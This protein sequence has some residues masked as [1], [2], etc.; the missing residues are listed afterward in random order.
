MTDLNTHIQIKKQKD[1][2]AISKMFRLILSIIL[3]GPVLTTDTLLPAFA[4]SSQEPSAGK[5]ER[6]LD[7]SIKFEDIKDI[8][9][10]SKDKT[11]IGLFKTTSDICKEILFSRNK[12]QN[13]SHPENIRRIL[14]LAIIYRELMEFKRARLLF[15]YLLDHTSNNMNGDH[16]KTA[17]LSDELGILY[18]ELGDY[19]KA[20]DLHLKALKILREK[21]INNSKRESKV[22]RN[23]GVVLANQGNFIKALSYSDQALAIEKDA[24]NNDNNRVNLA[25]IL[26]DLGNNYLNLGQL[27]KA[28]SYLE[29]A[30][31]IRED[32]LGINHIDTAHSYDD[33]PG[34]YIR[35]GSIKKAEELYLKSLK[36]RNKQLGESHPK[37]AITINR[38]ANLYMLMGKYDA[39]ESLL[40][41]SLKIRKDRLPLYHPHK[42]Y[43]LSGL[44][45]LYTKKDLT[46][47]AIKYA[48]EALYISQKGWGKDH[49]YTGSYYHKLGWLH[50][51][52]G[53]YIKSQ[54]Y[55]EKALSISEK[56][57]GIENSN[58]SRD[59]RFLWK[60]YIYQGKYREANLLAS[61]G[62]QM[63]IIKIQE[64]APYLAISDRKNFIRPLIDSYLPIFSTALTNDDTIDLAFTFRLNRQGL[65]QEIQ[66]RQSH[67]TILKGS[68][69]KL[70]ERLIATRKKI[71]SIGLSISE[72]N[73]LMDKKENFERQVYKLLPKY[74]PNFVQIEALA[75]ALPRDAILIEFQRYKPLQEKALFSNRRF[76]RDHYMA[77][78]IRPNQTIKAIDLGLAETID[79]K[80]NKS[81]R[82][83]EEKLSDAKRLWEEVSDLIIEPL[84][85]STKDSKVWFITPDSELNR[86]P[87]A[88]LK[89]PKKW[90]LP[91][92]KEFL[93]E[94]VKLRLLTTGRQLLTL[95]EKRYKP[96]NRA[97]VVANPNFNLKPSNL[98]NNQWIPLPSTEIEGAQ[99]AK[100]ISGKLL[101]GN[102]ATVFSIKNF[103]A[104]KLVHIASHSYFNS[105]K[106]SNNPMN[107]SGV[108]LAGA[109]SP[110][111]NNF[112]D[113]LLSA[114]E[115]S[116][117][118]WHGTEMVV[119]S[120]C[121]SGISKFQGGDAIYGLQRAIAIA[122]ARSSLL[123][124]WE[125]DDSA[126]A[127]FMHSYYK[128]LKSGKTRAKALAT[129]QKEFRKH[130]NIDWRHP[131]IWAA[132]QLSGDWGEMNL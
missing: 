5:R 30:K 64:E 59:I 90:W 81:L 3:I 132:F 11:N 96:N 15:T 39:A 1:F 110:Q 87:F 20:K 61:R 99:I 63:D 55:L 58:T 47:N 50:L 48:L 72:R 12:G 56:A 75:E 51:N 38:L 116:Q 91:W 13:L 28:Q 71:D 70:I 18:L 68:K 98:Q 102:E 2:S 21:N 43:S 111:T 131:F 89:A 74:K 130:V 16:N 36:I 122:G 4:E 88:A 32:L 124:L 126:T 52:K 35:Q 127:A 9:K 79:Q 103:K 57:Y 73:Y 115:I 112:E 117:L 25:N 94:R 120:G 77:F 105:E 14:D 10:Y 31:S 118:N 104:P 108:V 46:T 7:T 93:G 23:L 113:G 95:R 106:D 66:S 69:S 49:P 41:E 67:L 34:V 37:T 123:S 84:T 29:E 80:I 62:I 24:K 19:N 65:L 107:N 128:N 114:L 76:G 33:L 27:T 97:L 121:D 86:I 17:I 44:S 60:N 109:N 125:V 78:I 6:S 40:K 42:A 8:C 85:H 54:D 45:T 22:L 83:S 82:A 100:I 129:T 101:T 26:N 92:H 119:I 53:E